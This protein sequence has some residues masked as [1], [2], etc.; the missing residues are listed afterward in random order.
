MANKDLRGNFQKVCQ[1]LGKALSPEQLDS[2]VQ[3]LSFSAVKE[4]AMS[5]SIM[6]RNPEDNTVHNIPLLRKGTCGNWKNVFTVAQ[7]EAFD[8][9]Y[10]EKMSR[11]DPGLFSWSEYC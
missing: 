11:L 9:V 4:N 7:S 3:N 8:T 10:Q 6:L 2:A 1:F 5:N